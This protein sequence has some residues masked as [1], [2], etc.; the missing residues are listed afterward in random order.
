[1]FLTL[2]PTDERGLIYHNC[3]KGEFC[4]SSDCCSFWLKRNRRWRYFAALTRL[5]TA[6]Y[7]CGCETIDQCTPTPMQSEWLR[8]PRPVVI[9]TSCWVSGQRRE[10]DRQHEGCIRLERRRTDVQ[11]TLKLVLNINRNLLFVDIKQEWKWC[12][13]ELLF[14]I[15]LQALRL[16]YVQFR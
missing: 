13:T 16:L 14:P 6:D 5:E 11:I 1:M 12:S 15:S 4:Y 2:L 3:Y 9:Q 7:Y 10:I 8:V